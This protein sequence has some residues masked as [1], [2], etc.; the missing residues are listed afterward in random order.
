MFEY[1]NN[2]LCVHGGWL[3]KEGDILS[4]SNYDNLRGRK[5]I[6]EKRRACKGTPALIAYESLPKRFKDV[7]E[8]RIGGHPRQ[9]INKESALSQKLVFDEQAATYFAQYRN[10][11]G[12]TLAE[13]KQREYVSTASILNAVGSMA[14]AIQARRKT[15]SR[16]IVWEQL[17]EQVADIDQDAWPHRLPG[18]ARRLKARYKR[19]KSE[20]Y[21]SLIHGNLANKNSEKIHSDAGV[22]LLSRWADQVRRVPNL[23]HLLNEYNEKAVGE[24]WKLLSQEH[25]EE[26]LR[27]YLNRGDIKHL[28]YGHRY[29]DAASKEKFAYQHKTEMPTMRDS[30]W[31][32]DGTKLN[33]YYRYEDAEGRWK[34]ATCTVYEVMDAYSEVFLGMAVAKTESYEVQY[35]A[36][37]MAIQTAM[38]RPFEVRIDNQGGHK[39]LKKGH[40]LTD[41]AKLAIN[42]KPYNGKSKTIES[43]FGRFQMQNLKKK[44]YFT[45]QNVKAKSL[46][47]QQNK[48]FI[49]RQRIEDFPTLE[50]ALSAY[51][52]LREEWN[53]AKHH[54][55]GLSRI[56][57]YVNSTNPQA[58]SIDEL[59]IVR[60]MWVLR[61]KQITCNASGISFDEKKET[62]DY[63]VFSKPG[64]PDVAWLRRNVDKKFWIRFDPSNMDI[65]NLYE[66]DRDNLRFVTAAETKILTHR[67]IQEQEAW[68]SEYYQTIQHLNDEERKAAFDTMEGIL[69]EHDAT[70]EDYGL[71]TPGLL[72]I[73]STRKQATDIGKIMKSETYEDDTME[74]EIIGDEDDDDM[75]LAKMI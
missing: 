71:R 72:G 41:I 32:A 19:Y 18:N 40:F 12:H 31:Y 39:K 3:Y 58:P 49:A 25:G 10:A 53:N 17:T 2:I 28:W 64:I 62:Y 65:I 75:D 56:D 23:A 50:E 43:A 20:G 33:F 48:E 26:T 36:F 74:Y 34:K 5:Q 29:G 27:N 46:E 59:D 22:W 61:D 73:K 69:G 24:G 30:L 51:K 7:I 37:K 14:I 60:L 47:A 63:T 1:H 16:M 57:M 8:E 35:D 67:G 70:A 6:E 66:G 54:A 38:H 15:R 55:T 68:E 45:G 13:L 11:E 42:T 52:T 4:K 44:W 9:L 21:E